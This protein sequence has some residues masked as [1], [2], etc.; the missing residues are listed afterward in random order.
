MPDQVTIYNIRLHHHR[1][2]D[3]RPKVLAISWGS[4]V[5]AEES[6]QKMFGCIP[7]PYSPFVD[8]QDTPAGLQKRLNRMRSPESLYKARQKRI[9]A[10]VMK[11]DP[12]F[13]DQF[14]G[15][16]LENDAV[17]R[18]ISA[19]APLKHAGGN[20]RGKHLSKGQVGQIPVH[21]L[22]DSVPGGK[23]TGHLGGGE[24]CGLAGQGRQLGEFGSPFIG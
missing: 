6:V 11:K 19:P 17:F 12:L 7:F 1:P 2:A 21:T 16:A 3:I 14:I 23:Q 9:H 8:F 15:P 24:F 18:S 10:Y 5:N 22:L 20:T 13:Y 4:E